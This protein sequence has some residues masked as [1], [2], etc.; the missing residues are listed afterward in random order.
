MG[1]V[2]LMVIE[3]PRIEGVTRK[4]ERAQR[5][6]Q[7]ESNRTMRSLRQQVELGYREAAP[8]DTGQLARGLHAALSFRS[9]RLDDLGRAASVTRITMRSTGHTR[10]G[11]NYLPV[12][13]FGHIRQ[14]IEPRHRKQMKVYY[15][16]RAMPYLLRRRVSG[17][18]P[19]HDWVIEGERR[20]RALVRVHAR[21]LA[22]RIKE[23]HRGMV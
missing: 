14:V 15:L 7:E 8:E 17:A 5:R 6:A 9:V 23:V 3:T 2:D 12:S 1:R 21:G 11:F 18:R 10:D 19:S 22:V 13:R 16:G 4:L 20:A